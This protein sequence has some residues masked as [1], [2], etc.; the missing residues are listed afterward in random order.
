MKV[1]LVRILGKDVLDYNTADYNV[2]MLYLK[3]A[4]EQSGASVDL[5]DGLREEDFRERSSN[6]FYDIVGYN[7]H[8]LNIEESI[9]SLQFYKLNNP[10]SISIF[11]GDHA[12]GC[13]NELVSDIS[14]L[15]AVCVGEGEEIIQRLIELV[16][17]NPKSVKKI[18]ALYPE[19][20]ADIDNIDLDMLDDRFDIARISTSRGCPFDCS[21]CST[22]AIRKI[23]KVPTYRDINANKVTEIIKSAEKA[24]KRKIYIN[25]DLYVANNN[26][27]RKRAAIIADRIINEKINIPY[28][29]QI[30]ADSYLKKHKN[31]LITLRKSGLRE[32]F[33]GL[34]SGSKNTLQQ[35]NKEIDPDGNVEAVNLYD[36]VGIKINAGN[37]VAAPDV[38]EQ[39][40]FDSIEMFSECDIAYLFFRRVTFRAAVFPGTAIEKQMIKAGRLSE[41]PRYFNRTYSFKEKRLGEVVEYLEQCMPEFLSKIGAKSFNIRS[42]CLLKKYDGELSDDELKLMHKVLSAWSV[43][44]AKILKKIF[45]NMNTVTKNDVVMMFDD[46][47][48]YVEDVVRNLLP[49]SNVELIDE[50]LF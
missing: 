13:P 43:K 29:V 20:F 4:A 50:E 22:P 26:K 35:F 41:Q 17:S 21:F 33:L 16:R 28:K 3:W 19:S 10:H 46:Y 49:I 11:G 48:S 7:V 47:T 30:R 14:E 23:T 15:D 12:A 24:G 39:D 27:S 44:S 2:G 6:V 42:K 5:F 8:Y 18:G 9:N 34:E 25:D 45:G 37:L 31:D 38:T 40:I 36:E 32:V 1:A